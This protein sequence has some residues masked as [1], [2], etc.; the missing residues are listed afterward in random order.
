MYIIG[1]PSIRKCGIFITP[2]EAL[3]FS[4]GSDTL[5][6]V[7]N[8]LVKQFLVEEMASACKL[9]CKIN[10][11]PHWANV[12]PIDDT[13]SRTPH[14]DLQRRYRTHIGQRAVEYTFGLNNHALKS[15]PRACFYSLLP[16]SPSTYKS[17]AS[18]L[19]LYK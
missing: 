13:G 7:Q 4:I 1:A 14:P 19:T 3:V 9:Q 17:T 11:N 10:A 2:L 5:E 16:F 12:S 6:R 18:R 8:A 15:T